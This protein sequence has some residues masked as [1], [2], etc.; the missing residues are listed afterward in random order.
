MFA[1]ICFAAI[2]TNMVTVKVHWDNPWEP[3]EKSY[4]D[5]LINK[6]IETKTCLKLLIWKL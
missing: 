1:V 2:N 3:I 5:N 6:K 4:K